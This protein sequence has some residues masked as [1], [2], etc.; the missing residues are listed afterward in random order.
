MKGGT[1]T[2]GRVLG[3]TRGGAG[4][5][6][7]SPVASDIDEAITPEIVDLHATLTIRSVSLFS[8]YPSTS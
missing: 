5:D 2:T 6:S 1:N 4:E 7:S 8:I 3:G